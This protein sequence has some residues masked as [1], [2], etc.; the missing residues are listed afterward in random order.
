MET[1]IPIGSTKYR[2]IYS[3]IIA[4]IYSLFLSAVQ[5]FNI[6]NSIG[7]TSQPSIKWAKGHSVTQP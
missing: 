3:V 5:R 7:P 2:I 6:C 1:M 4:A